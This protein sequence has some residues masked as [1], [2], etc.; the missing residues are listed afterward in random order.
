MAAVKS[1]RGSSRLRPPRGAAA[2]FVSQRRAKQVDWER[3]DR[4][5]LNWRMPVVRGKTCRPSRRVLYELL[6]VLRPHPPGGPDR[7]PRLPLAL[8]PQRRPSSLAR[9]TSDRR[10]PRGDRRPRPHCGRV[11]APRRR[12]RQPLALDTLPIAKRAGGDATARLCLGQRVKG[13]LDCAVAP[14]IQGAMVFGTDAKPA[15]AR[16]RIKLSALQGTRR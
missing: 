7:R 4:V 2:T 3:G 15:P 13:W 12:P 5:G 6:E 10:V 11:E 8:R 1:R 14:S 16:R 9:V